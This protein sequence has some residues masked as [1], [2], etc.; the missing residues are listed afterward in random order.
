MMFP[1][2]F[3]VS[4]SLALAAL[5]STGAYYITVSLH[6][7][8][9]KRYFFAIIFIAPKGVM[10][11]SMKN[12]ITVKSGDVVRLRGSTDDIL[13]IRPRIFQGERRIIGFFIENDGTNSSV[14]FYE[15]D[16]SKIVARGVDK[17]FVRNK[18]LNLED[19]CS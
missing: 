13:V 17:M 15:S 3:H 14:D 5:S 6:P 19:I 4:V 12:K 10:S 11:H 9:G 16:V 18:D 8:I 2:M 7:S 1:V